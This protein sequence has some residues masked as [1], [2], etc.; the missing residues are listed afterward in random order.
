MKLGMILPCMW[1]GQTNGHLYSCQ[2]PQEFNTRTSGGFIPLEATSQYPTEEAYL[3]VCEARTKWQER[4]EKAEAELAKGKNDGWFLD[5]DLF[6][7]RADLAAASEREQWYIEALTD[8]EERGRMKGVESAIKC[9]EE[10]LRCRPMTERGLLIGKE[11]IV[12][13]RAILK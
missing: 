11:C 2:R 13:I 1:C 4:A 7:L 3:A 12:A 6:I 9:C 5:K 8:A 10:L